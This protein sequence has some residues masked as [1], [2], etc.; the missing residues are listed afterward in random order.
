MDRGVASD[1]PEQRSDYGKKGSQP[2]STAGA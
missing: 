2:S 1:R